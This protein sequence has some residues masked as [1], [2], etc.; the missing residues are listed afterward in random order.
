[1]KK[2]AKKALFCPG[3]FCFARHPRIPTP[4]QTSL[5]AAEAAS[6]LIAF[7]LQAAAR[8]EPVEFCEK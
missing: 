2:I 4:D 6:V 1:M 3:K 5:A 8:R 7:W